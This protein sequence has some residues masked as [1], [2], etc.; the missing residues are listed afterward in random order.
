M[1]AFVGI[2]KKK[3][4]KSPISSP[5]KEKRERHTYSD[6]RARP[7]VSKCVRMVLLRIWTNAKTHRQLI[8]GMRFSVSKEVESRFTNIISRRRSIK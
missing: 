4:T 3:V 1:R 6:R 2:L 5:R 7:L 8:R